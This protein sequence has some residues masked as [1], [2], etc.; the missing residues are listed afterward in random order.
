MVSEVTSKCQTPPKD[1]TGIYLVPLCFKVLN[2]KK[3]IWTVEHPMMHLFL[4][5]SFFLWSET[6]TEHT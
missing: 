6:L 3:E 1:N 4:H 5:F 2:I